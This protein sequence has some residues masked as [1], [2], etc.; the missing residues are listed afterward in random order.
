MAAVSATKSYKSSEKEI[1]VLKDV[2]ALIQRIN[3]AGSLNSALEIV[4][5]EVESKLV[6]KSGSI[7]LVNEQSDRLEPLVWSHSGLYYNCWTDGRLPHTFKKGEG[8]AGW[9]WQ[10]G[11]SVRCP[12]VHQDPR[13]W[14]SGDPRALDVH[15]LLC[16]PLKAADST[17]LGVI[18]LD[19]TNINHFTKE[20]ED[21]LQRLAN[22]VASS[23]ARAKQLENAQRGL[24]QRDNVI[25]LGQQVAGASDLHDLLCLI[26]KSS[27]EVVGGNASSDLYLYDHHKEPWESRFSSRVHYGEQQAGERCPRRDGMGAWVIKHRKPLVCYELGRIH[28]G[29]LAEGAKSDICLPLMVGHEIVG[30]LYVY[31]RDDRQFYLE[32]QRLLEAFCNTAAL[33]IRNV[34]L[35][36]ALAQVQ[37]I[38]VIISAHHDLAR[39][40][41]LVI[42]KVVK[43]TRASRGWI[44]LLALGPATD[45]L[46]SMLMHQACRGFTAEYTSLLQRGIGISGMVA[47]TGT[48]VIAGNVKRYLK[49]HPEIKPGDTP[50]DTKSKLAVPLKIGHTVIGVLN[51]ESTSENA[52]IEDDKQLLEMIADYVAIAI[53]N[54]MPDEIAKAI[55]SLLDLDKAL[56]LVLEVMLTMTGAQHGTFRLL[57]KQTNE[58]VLKASR[59][60][61]ADSLVQARLKVGETE[62][63]VGWVAAKKVPVR[64]PDLA[65][66]PWAAFNRP[67]AAD[68]EMKSLLAVPLLGAHGELEGVLNIESPRLD[69]FSEHAEQLAI[70]LANRATIAIQRAKVPD[71]IKEIADK[72]VSEDE[73]E[74]LRVIFSKAHDLVNAPVCAIWTIDRHDRNKLVLR[75]SIGREGI[76]DPEYVMLELDKSFIGMAIQQ[77]EIIYSRDVRKDERFMRRNLAEKHG[78]ASALVVPLLTREK[79]PV[80]VFSVYTLSEREFSKWEQEL[81][82]AFASQAA[83]AIQNA[84]R[85]AE[86]EKTKDDLLA[87]GA[88]ASMGLFASEWKH[89]V[90]QKTW[91]IRNY[92]SVLRDLVSAQEEAQRVLAEIERIAEEIEGTPFP[93]PLPAKPITI[94][95]PVAADTVLR[96][97][98]HDWC[99]Q[100]RDV[101]ID[102]Q[103]DCGETMIA[104]DR[105]WL[106]AALQK[107]VNNAL[108]AM[109]QGG[110]LTVSS[111]IIGDQVEIRLID[112]GH[113]IL[114]K[115]LPYF[116]KERVPKE[117]GE[118][119]TGMGVMIAKFILRKYGGDLRLLWSKAGKGTALS[120]LI[121]VV[122]NNSGA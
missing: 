89:L 22:Y 102:F 36:Q 112:T 65:Q 94:P 95:W 5:Q 19:S 41:D 14:K 111:Q 21:I 66:Q 83:I 121:P 77:K 13:Y 9:V 24:K 114:E 113:G 91:A 96:E 55:T 73:K 45:L 98:V 97:K 49:E 23:I 108:K 110:T 35:V 93:L 44:K 39:I 103:L 82:S 61:A 117:A 88:V 16:V 75:E 64:I 38:G 32:D 72:L 120:I 17:I 107:L 85:Y 18:N 51:L 43:L 84:E 7:L 92:A 52:F 15:S 6:V 58:L 104:I 62:S 109:P 90:N 37:E 50:K 46:S 4:L 74:L 48:P 115:Y 8:I 47:E 99:R 2:I 10:T 25:E 30:L 79:E 3:E 80:G 122:V 12:D 53:L 34:R 60:V 78:W 119:G 57:D 68:I 63:I 29:K 86:L 20:H 105:E 101:K 42:D 67:L 118:P 106:E 33:A 71:A 1:R 11:E 81:L 54:C 31:R 116:L 100:A 70:A 76:D 40:F 59:G 87:A 28:P 27:V 56:D 26:T 69:A